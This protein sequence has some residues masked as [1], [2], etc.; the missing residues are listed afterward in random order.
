MGLQGCGVRGVTPDKDSQQVKHRDSQVD[1]G[2]Q[3]EGSDPREGFV[4]SK[5]L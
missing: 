4:A 2:V 3:G 5:T 1:A